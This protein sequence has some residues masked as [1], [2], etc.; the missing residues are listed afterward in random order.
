MRERN[1]G[2]ECGRRTSMGDYGARRKETILRRM[3]RVYAPISR[4]RSLPL[5]EPIQTA[6]NEPLESYACGHMIEEKELYRK[7]ISCHS[8][9]LISVTSCAALRVP[10]LRIMRGWR[11]RTRNQIQKTEAV[12]STL[13]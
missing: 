6:S 7:Q 9:C 12:W 10:R 2:R 5:L 1:G 11:K 13:S 4:I 8:Y 3:R